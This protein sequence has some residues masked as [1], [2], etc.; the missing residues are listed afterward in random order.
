MTTNNP[1]VVLRDIQE[2]DMPFVI[3]SWFNS[4]LKAKSCIKAIYDKEQRILIKRILANPKTTTEILCLETDNDHIIGFIC[5]QGTSILHYVYIK[6]PFRKLG[7]G[8]N[9]VKTCLTD[10]KIFITHTNTLWTDAFIKAFF[11][12]YLLTNS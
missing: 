12:P 8:R 6:S 1:P 2:S 11:N 3:D 5:Y 7:L 4:H 10:S 9:L